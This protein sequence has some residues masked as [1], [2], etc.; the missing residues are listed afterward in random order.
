MQNM[1]RQFLNT[2]NYFNIIETRNGQ[3]RL[4]Y[5]GICIEDKALELLKAN[6]YRYATCKQVKNAIREYYSDD[7][8]PDWAFS[9][10]SDLWQIGTVQKLLNN[11]NRLNVYAKITY[12]H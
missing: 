10:I 6:K 4:A 12:Q 9:E 2:Y 3:Q 8:T 11:I 5:V 7:C 1:E